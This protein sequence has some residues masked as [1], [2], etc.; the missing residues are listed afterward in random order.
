MCPPAAH[1]ILLPI[2]YPG[3]KDPTSH[4]ANRAAHLTTPPMR[5]PRIC[6][7]PTH[8]AAP[9]LL[10]WRRVWLT[11]ALLISFDRLPHPHF[12][13]SASPLISLHRASMVI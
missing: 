4:R 5:C 7:A 2:E 8:N 11:G 13:F 10:F 3:S 12:L 1:D 6:K 9:Q